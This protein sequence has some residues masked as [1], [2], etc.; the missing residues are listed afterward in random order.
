MIKIAEYEESDGTKRH[1]F[2][3]GEASNPPLVV[4]NKES[5]LICARTFV[6]LKWELLKGAVNNLP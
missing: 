4:V 6:D 5:S 3:D 1:V 2:K